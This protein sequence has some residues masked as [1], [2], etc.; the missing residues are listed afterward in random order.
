MSLDVWLTAVRPVTVF[1]EN[2]THNLGKMAMVVHLSNGKTLYDVMWRPDE[3]GY[4]RASEIAPLL[5][6]AVTILL[7][8][9]DRLMELNPSNGWGHYGDLVQFV[10]AYLKSC[11]ENPD[12]IIGVC[13]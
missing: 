6:E 1:E 5:S 7:S 10:R 8:D 11:T 13:R 9:R 4:T 12:G 3:H 2:I